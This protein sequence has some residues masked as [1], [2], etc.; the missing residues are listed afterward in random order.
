MIRKRAF[1]GIFAVTIVLLCLIIAFIAYLDV[2]FVTVFGAI[3]FL[4]SLPC[5]LIPAFFVVFVLNITGSL[6]Y[7]DTVHRRIGRRGWLRGNRFEMGFE[8]IQQ[9]FFAPCGRGVVMIFV[10]DRFNK[11]YSIGRKRSYISL[12]YS[13]K[14]LDFIRRAWGGPIDNYMGDF[15]SVWVKKV[16]KRKK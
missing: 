1:P 3:G 7:I 12:N 4:Y 8:D 15:Y 10:I 13:Q 16:E 11:H 9:V 14:N 2:R 5:L 6:V